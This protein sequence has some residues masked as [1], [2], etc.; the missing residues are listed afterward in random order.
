MKTPIFKEYES[1]IKEY[2]EKYG[3]NTIVLMQVGSFYEIYAILNDTEK[4]GEINIY[5]ICQNLM[6]IAVAKKT[7]HILMGGFQ[8]PYSKKFIKLLIEHNYSVVLVNQVTEKPNILRKVSQIISPGTYLEEFN[9][10]ENNYLM[11]IYIESITDSFISVGLSIIDISTGKN[12]VYQI[13]KPQDTNYWKDELNRLIHFYSPRE[14]IFQTCNITLT[15]DDIINYWDIQNASI[16]I[17]H[18]TSKEHVSI[19]YH[20]ELFKKAFSIE[21]MLSPI[22]YLDM[23]CKDQQRISY[24]Y[25]L[26]YLYEHNKEIIRN[27][28]FPES[29]ENRNYLTLTS[30]SVRQLNVINNYSY[31]KGKNESLYSICNECKFI[32]GKRLLKQHLLYP[33]TDPDILTKRYNKI[34]TFIQDDFFT[35]IRPNISRLTDLDKYIRKMSLSSIDPVSFH[36]LLIS[37]NFANRIHALI[38]SNDICNSLYQEFNESISN[39]LQFYKDISSKFRISSLVESNES[40]FKQGVYPSIDECST[41]IQEI[42]E[43]LSTIQLK[44]NSLLDNKS[45]NAIKLDFNDKFHWHL[46]CTKT[47]S[48]TIT[49]RLK[50]IVSIPDYC[51]DLSFKPKDNSNVLLQ[52]NIINQL[53]DDYY[54]T[55][56]TLNTYNKEYYTE[57]I[58]T[59]YSTYCKDL[60]QFHIYLSDI[61]VATT[62][63]KVAIQNN[64]CKPEIIESTKSCL[65]ATDIR[66]P[67]VERINDN[68]EYITNNIS[69]GMDDIDGV[70]LFGT[71]ACGKSTLMK[72][73][74]LSIIMAQ[75]GFYVPCR[76]FK[77]KPYTQIFTRILNNDNIFRS[78][79]SFAVEMSELRSIFQN[80]DKYSLILGDELCS[81]TETISAISIVAKSL[82]TLSNLKSTY[83]ITSHL[84]QLTDLPL[85]TNLDNLKIYHLKIDY[86]E[87]HNLVYNRKLIEG[88]GPPV[89]GLKV[90]E[91]M[92]LSKDFIE[93]ANSLLNQ[94]LQKESLINEKKSQYHTSLYMDT[95]EI[96]KA[97]AEE[98]HHI[99][100]QCTANKH[101]MIDHHHKNK[102]HNLV[103]LCKQCHSKVTYNKMIIHGWKQTSRGRQLLYEE[104]IQKGNDKSSYSQ[105]QLN[106]IL[107]YKDKVM[108]NTITKKICVDLLE[109]EHNIK[110]SY[111]KLNDIFSNA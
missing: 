48:K 39:Y 86:D 60:Q 96:C 29:I 9:N 21:S 37:Y 26:L 36:T 30:N 81:G 89:Y 101:K 32:G 99:K 12:F 7:N 51:Q 74:G 3:E 4:Y 65:V 5:H 27:I 44:L 31:Y 46:Y 82:E 76:E 103:A 61:D 19:H 16:Q 41:K 1:Y 53:L 54:T 104:T 110:L 73:I 20:N 40:Y 42:K 47:R 90:C 38:Q 45:T 67:I 80:T 22:E 50:N 111:P 64:Y 43:Q 58:D 68:E 25:M 72:A 107:S 15:K 71:N 35:K 108:N 78:Q 105:E 13:D 34:E 6:N 97:P 88:S 70:L 8:L 59:L 28:N 2:K 79:S 10:Q 23:V 17:N 95:C 75:A 55:I 87:N 69:L 94:L 93:G 14:Y 56:E 98:T 33:T 92:G 102:K 63:A 106:I 18:F 49:C 91:A 85:V 84:H 109:I 57:T 52:N 77:Y 11:S 62:A 100:E 83:I 24:A 66:H